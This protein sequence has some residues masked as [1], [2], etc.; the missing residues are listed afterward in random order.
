MN[1]IERALFNHSREDVDPQL[2]M[3]WDPGWYDTYTALRLMHQ[4]DCAIYCTKL[5]DYLE[6]LREVAQIESQYSE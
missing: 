2:Y 3:L 1:I 5:F 4:T 6:L